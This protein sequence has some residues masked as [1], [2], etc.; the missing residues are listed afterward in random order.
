MKPGDTLDLAV[1]KAG[2]IGRAVKNCNGEKIATFSDLAIV[3][4]G[5]TIYAFLRH[6]GYLGIGSRFIPVPCK[7][8]KYSVK[9]RAI[10]LNVKNKLPENAY[11]FDE[12]L[13]QDMGQPGRQNEIE[14]YCK[15]M[16]AEQAS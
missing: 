7:E 4:N 11:N 15:E 13:W 6:G 10:V 9:D 14:K 12:K 8:R 2:V 16:Q 5:A 3:K 1:V